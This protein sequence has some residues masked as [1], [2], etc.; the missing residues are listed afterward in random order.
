MLFALV[1]DSGVVDNKCK[2]YWSPFVL[3][4]A[5][6]KFALVVSVFIETFFKYLIGK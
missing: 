5:R 4:K 3:P 2:L 6:D 1:L